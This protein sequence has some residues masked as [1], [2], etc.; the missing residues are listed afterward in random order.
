M[1]QEELYRSLGLSNFHR[2]G[3]AYGAITWKDSATKWTGDRCSIRV[4]ERI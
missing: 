2:M 4:R 3:C 1:V